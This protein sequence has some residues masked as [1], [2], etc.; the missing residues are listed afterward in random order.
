MFPL[1]VFPFLIINKRCCLK[2]LAQTGLHRVLL[3]HVSSCQGGW[4][5]RKGS[6][7]II[8]SVDESL[9]VFVCVS[10]QRKQGQES[11]TESIK[12]RL[13]SVMD[14][15]ISI[16]KISFIFIACHTAISER[17]LVWRQEAK[18]NGISKG[19]T[20][21]VELSEPAEQKKEN[22]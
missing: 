9:C 11:L 10:C 19:Y 5:I 12:K 1:Q 17:N 18:L 16:N 6:S 15:G 7:I 14:D 3:N 13:M 21:T 22:V 2:D 20:I 8:V 4:S